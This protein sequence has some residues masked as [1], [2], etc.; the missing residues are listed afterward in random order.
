MDISANLVDD[1]PSY[2]VLSNTSSITFTTCALNIHLG[3]PFT[4]FMSV[5]RLQ[6]LLV[7]RLGVWL[8]F[9]LQVVHEACTNRTQGSQQT[10]FTKYTLLITAIF[11]SIRSLLQNCRAHRWCGTFKRPASSSIPFLRMSSP[12]SSDNIVSSSVCSTSK[13]LSS[14]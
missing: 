8:S 2:S 14:C 7:W 10:M 5:R 13:L 4:A 12:I 3:L 11:A 6:K 9:L 1:H